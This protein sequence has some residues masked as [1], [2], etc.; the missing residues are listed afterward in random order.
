MKEEAHIHNLVEFGD[1][2]CNT[3]GVAV[4]MADGKGDMQC[5]DNKDSSEDKV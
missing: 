2:D 5:F 4:Y 1:T 3:L